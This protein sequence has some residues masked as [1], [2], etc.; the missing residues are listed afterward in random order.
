[1]EDGTTLE[2]LRPEVK[3]PFQVEQEESR[4]AVGATV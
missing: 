2:L 3:D 4:R 1:M